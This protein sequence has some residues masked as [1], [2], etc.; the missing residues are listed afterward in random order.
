MITD[1]DPDSFS[2]AAVLGGYLAAHAIWCVSDGSVLIPIYAWSS[3]GQRSLERLHL[4]DS[5]QALQ[6]G[7]QRL[8]TNPEGSDAAVLIIDLI[9]RNPEGLRRDALRLVIDDR[10]SG[11][12]VTVAV[13][14]RPADA[15]GGFA[16]HQ[17]I[18]HDANV[19]G[20]DVESMITWF[21]GGVTE[22]EQGAE[23]W[24]R[25]WDPAG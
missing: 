14:Y 11:T 25:H 13:P 23:T 15:P 16:V 21:Y 12:R 4:E 2:E 17:P 1:L 19:D 7:E 24:K 9:L 5:N 3:G 8:D 18:F 20:F 6:H 10:I 22:H